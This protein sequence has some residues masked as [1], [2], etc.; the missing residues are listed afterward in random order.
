MAKPL[1]QQAQGARS[2]GA[3]ILRR[4]LAAKAPEDK[5]PARNSCRCLHRGSSGS[6]I[7]G[8]GLSAWAAK[9]VGG[10]PGLREA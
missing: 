5:R 9:P 3:G 2:Q 4:G 10:S 7:P 6:V 1:E 8:G